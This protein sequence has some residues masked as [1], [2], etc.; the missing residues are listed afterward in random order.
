MSFLLES[1]GR[2]LLG[3]LSGAFE[4]LTAAPEAPRNPAD[5]TPADPRDTLAH[6]RVGS[7]LLRDGQAAAALREYQQALSI[8]ENCRPARIGL[9]CAHDDLSE[10]E[11][12]LAE[13]RTL[14]REDAANPAILFCIGYCHERCERETEAVNYYR[15]ALA[16]C[17]T[18]RNAH[19]RLAAIFL[20]RG[21]VDMAIRH[22]T[23][24]CRLDPDQV[25]LHL[26]LANLLLRSGDAVGA[27]RR[28]EKALSLEPD[29]WAVHNDAVSAYEEAGLI[30][31]AIEHLHKLLEHKP[32]DAAARLRLGDLYSRIGNDAAATAQYQRAVEQVPDF[33][34]ANV[35]MGTQHLR[36]GR[37]QEA[38]RWFAFALELNDRLLSAYVGLGIAQRAAGRPS[39]AESAFELAR[40]VEPNSTL[41]FGEIARMHLKSAA[42]QAAN[43][44][45][46]P[47][48]ADDLIGTDATASGGACAN[49]ADMHG[50]SQAED[51]PPRAEDSAVGDLMA[52][53][54]ERHRRALELHPNHADLHYRLGL[55]LRNRGQLN[56]AID[57]YRAALTINPCYAKAL[58]KLGVA[59]HESGRIDEAVDAFTRALEVQPEYVDLHYRLGLLFAQRQQF[60]LAVERFE[61]ALRANPG[62]LE[63]QANLALALQNMGLIDRAHAT[64]QVIRDATPEAAPP[65]K[66]PREP[67]QHARNPRPNR[68]RNR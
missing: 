14:Q 54:I 22:Y 66:N 26:T 42:G 4:A 52:I 37:H 51:T 60:E 7:R 11:R 33:L 27:V 45:L 6:V 15:D 2:G 19:E 24:L 28:F 67:L 18:L 17:P 3:R 58:I 5:E 36:A 53:Q 1:L 41:L 29:N 64:G 61:H 63:C 59:L 32:D 49:A 31:E 57:R 38:A 39:E 65:V 21:N 23:E 56:E 8:D 10:P 44:W 46:N 43:E 55:L 9:A 47:A 40:H 16:I 48:A 25:E 12:A 30:R 20:R 34:E 68:R 35:K 13:L 62:N 50:T